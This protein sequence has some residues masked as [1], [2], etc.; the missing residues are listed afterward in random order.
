MHDVT[1]IGAGV[2]G[3]FLA[4]TLMKEHP[5]L[6][7]HVIDRGKKLEDRICGQDKGQPC[8]CVGPCQKYVGFAGLGKSEG[9][10]NYT[11]DFGGGLCEKIG[12]E[13]AL[14]MMKKVDQILCSF[15][16]DAVEK[17]STKNERLSQRAARYS[18]NVLSTEVRHLGTTIAKE[19][20]QNMYDCMK[21]EISFTFEAEITA[22]VKEKDGFTITTKGSEVK[23][24]QIVMATGKSGSRWLGEIADQLGLE[25]GETRLDLGIRVEMKE[26]QLDAILQET[27]E[28]KLNYITPS[29]SATTY[30]MNPRGRIIRKHQH[31]LV[32][33]DGQNEREED[34]PSQNLNFTLFVPRFFESYPKAMEE[35]H[36]IIGT[37]N[38]G[39]GRIVLQRLGD[40][41]NG[42]TPKQGEASSIR[43]SI[44]AEAGDLREEVPE[45]YVDAL[46][47]FFTALEGLLGEK[48]DRGTL[49]YGLDSKFY[50]AKIHTDD[51]F[52][53]NIPGLYLIG[54][55]SGDTHS[56]SQAAASGVYLGEQMKA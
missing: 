38:R 9:K 18:L 45:I 22:I 46:L 34:A 14:R 3:I 4:Y 29:Y 47:E 52:Q 27:F 8:T 20:F 32:M 26:N 56:L 44:N 25:A 40:L 13:R 15:G 36:R 41:L 33:P 55:C 16:G 1:I 51:T 28:T 50:E 30:C 21:D 35:A 10:F 37:I 23:S 19:V 31:G 48:I 53:T 42:Y 24:R 2:S 12:G 11:N 39:R 17:Y 54:D 7:V 6:D 43:P 5:E 49:L